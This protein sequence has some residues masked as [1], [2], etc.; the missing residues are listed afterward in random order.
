VNARRALPVALLLVCVAC[1]YR[2]VYAG[3]A[4]E[5]LHVVQVRAPVAGAAAADEVTSGVREELAREGALA[6]GDGFPR[7]EVEVTRLDEVSDA[8]AAA[9]GPAPGGRVPLAR[10]TDVGV[11][12]RAWLVRGPGG[13]R[14]RDTGDVRVLAAVGATRAGDGIASADPSAIDSLRH[15]DALRAAGRRV[16]TRLAR[17]ILGEPAPSMDE[18]GDETGDGTGDA[19]GEWQERAP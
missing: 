2:A 15:E 11:V 9:A 5:R 4:G 1:G 16:G 3:G 18:T 12:A 10:A 6:A 8:I 19:T 14:L 17:R 13:E 7:V